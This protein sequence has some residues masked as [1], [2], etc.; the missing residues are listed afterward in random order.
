MLVRLTKI[1]SPILAVLVLAGCS[2]IK[3]AYNNVDWVLLGKADHYLNLT[4]SQRELAA[5][6]VAA[7]MEVHRREE[8]PIYVTTMKEARVMLADNFTPAELEVIKVRIPAVYRRTMRDTIPGIVIL[9]AEVDDAQIDHLQA[10]FEERNREFEE[11][12]MP[13]SMQV[14]LDRRVERSA[15]MFEFFIG[16]LRPDQLE[17]VARHRNAMPLTADDWLAYHQV[18][19]KE[20]LAM[21]RRKASNEELER[22]LVAWWVDLANQPPVLKRKMEL[23]TDGWSQMLLALD[24]TLDDRQ[25]QK[26]LDK[27]DLYIKELGELVPEKTS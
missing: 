21:L 19:Q 14:R 2:T 24:K 4:D 25:R 7:R 5:Q 6:V 8:L 18:H 9:L 26:L 3:F 17:L 15:E 27:L 1:A 23:N 13:E 11:N 22:Y 20:L 12:F 16:E 10:Q